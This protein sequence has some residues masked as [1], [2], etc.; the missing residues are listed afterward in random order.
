MI[1]TVIRLIMHDLAVAFK[2]KT[3]YLIVCIPLFVYGT[4]MLVDSTDAR[5]ARMRIALLQTES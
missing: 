2:N 4:L 3:V 5:T 1:R